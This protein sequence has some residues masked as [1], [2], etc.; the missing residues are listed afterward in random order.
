MDNYRAPTPATV[1]GGTA[2]DTPAARQL[3]KDGGAVWIDVLAAPHRPANL[4]AC[5]RMAAG[6]AARYSRQLVAAR[7]R[8]RRTRSPSSKPISA[9]TS[10]GS[11]K[12]VAARP[13][14]FY[15]LANCWM[16]W[17]AAKRA[18]SWGYTRVYWYRDGTDGWEAAKLPLRNG[19]T[20]PGIPMSRALGLVWLLALSAPPPALGRRSHRRA[21]P[22]DSGRS[23]ARA[24]GRSFGKIARKSRFE[25]FRF[26][27]GKALCG[28][29]CSARN[30]SA[31]IFRVPICL[32]RSLISPGSCGRILPTPICRMPAS[33]AS[34]SSSGLDY[35]AARGPD[36]QGRQF[37]RG[38][39][40]RPPQPV[41]PARR[42]FHRREDGR[43]HEEPVHGFD[44]KR[45]FRRR[46]GR[47]QFSK[48][49][50]S[51]AL[52]RFAKLSGANLAGAN[53]SGADLSG[54][55]LT[56]ADLTGADATEAD[57]GGA[58]LTNARGLDTMKGWHP[59]QRSDELAL[60]R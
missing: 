31:L 57:F 44:A 18:A 34:W 22:R 16:S 7:C 14:V 12:A 2:L 56:G 36:I 3:W 11:A 51:L 60:L 15:C 49:D 41:R 39:H 19:G 8:P 33:S 13:F 50:L 42:Q 55:D 6:A 20:G 32:V 53:L 27:R 46:S 54:A 1:A 47:R 30:W 28:R 52:L 5:G 59:P 26:Q 17:N 38:A 37:L 43:G 4:P 58:V 9:P 10:S 21:G 48:A 40:P 29:T 24:A 45:S 25:Q 23:L 35:S